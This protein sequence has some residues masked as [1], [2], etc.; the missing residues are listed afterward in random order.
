[1]KARHAEALARAVIIF[2]GLVAI[3]ALLSLGSGR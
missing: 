2:L 1:V 3:V